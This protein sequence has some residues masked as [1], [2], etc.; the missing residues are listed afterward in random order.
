MDTLSYESYWGK[1]TQEVHPKDRT[2]WRPETKAQFEVTEQGTFVIVINNIETDYQFDIA[3][4]EVSAHRNGVF[5]IVVCGCGSIG[6]AGA[7]V[8]VSQDDKEIVWG[9]FWHGQCGG[10][11]LPEDDLKGLKV[12]ATQNVYIKPPLRFQRGHYE[13]VLKNLL[14]EL[15]RH[16][17]SYSTREYFKDLERYKNGSLYRL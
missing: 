3:A 16:E 5:P 8:E 1:V 6:C 12:V 17:D 13:A 4:L 10:E 14:N 7:Y 9:K 2:D 11:P 15:H